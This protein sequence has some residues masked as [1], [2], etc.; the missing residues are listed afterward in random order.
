M[1]EFGLCLDLTFFACVGVSLTEDYASGLE[2]S[3]EIRCSAEARKKFTVP[4]RAEK[5]RQLH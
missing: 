1:E 3:V 5:L 4:I 2:C